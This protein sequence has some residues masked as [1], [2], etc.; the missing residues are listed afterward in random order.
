M[1]NCDR[2]ALQI[3]DMYLRFG[4][5]VIPVTTIFEQGTL[6]TKTGEDNITFNASEKADSMICKLIE[7]ANHLCILFS[8]L[9]YMHSLPEDTLNTAR[10]TSSPKV[11]IV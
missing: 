4:H 2:N 1:G 6:R 5:P 7:S 10:E 11:S 3:S 9:K 8:S